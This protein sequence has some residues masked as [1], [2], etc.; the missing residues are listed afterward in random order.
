[1]AMK[2]KWVNKTTIQCFN[3]KFKTL[4]L[5]N[6]N[7]NMSSVI[8]NEIYLNKHNITINLLRLYLVRKP[9]NA[10]NQF[11]LIII[12]GIYFYLN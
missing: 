9:N 3:N 4:I 6:N 1:M 2:L 11:L 12:L 7:F 10:L 5:S 8:V